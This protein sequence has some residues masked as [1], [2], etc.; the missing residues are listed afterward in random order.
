M[1]EDWSLNGP[2]QDEATSIVVV[3]RKEK[4]DLK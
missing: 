4:G 1:V 3:N 2:P